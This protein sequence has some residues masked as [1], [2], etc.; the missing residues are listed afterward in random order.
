MVFDE[1]AAQINKA[2]R[3]FKGNARHD[4]VKAAK[5]SNIY[6]NSVAIL[7]GSHG[8]GKSFA[9]L[10]ESLIICRANP[11]T[12]M[13]IFIKKKAYDPTVESIRPLIEAAGTKFVE[14]EYDEAEAFVKMIFHY[15]QVYNKMKRAIAH[16][17]SGKPF[18]EFEEDLDDAT[19]RMPP[20][21]MKLWE[22]RICASTG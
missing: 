13:L 18:D 10:T 7:T 15:K 2:K 4:V 11:N 12:H 19:E 8:Q 21:C 6:L 5:G 14:I 1:E 16:K 20:R 9:A 22:L 17:H 3:E